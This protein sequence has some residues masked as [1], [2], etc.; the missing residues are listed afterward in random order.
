MTYDILIVDDQEDIRQLLSD[1][2]VDEG[3]G[4]RV[5]ASGIEALSSIKTKRPHLILLDVWLKEA[6]CDGLHVLDLIRQI[7]PELPIIMISGHSSI[8]TAIQALKTGAYDF[9]EKPFKTERLLNTIT[10]ALEHVALRQEIDRLNDLNNHPLDFVGQSPMAEQSRHFIGSVSK[11]KSRVLLAGPSGSGKKLIASLIHKRSTR[12]PNPL[13]VVKCGLLNPDT[14]DV[15]FYGKEASTVAGGVAIQ[16]GLLEK[17]HGGTIVLD[18]VHRTPAPIQ[19]RLLKVVQ[20]QR[21]QRVGGKIALENDVRFISTTEENLEKRVT[22]GTFRSDLFYRLN[23]VSLTLDPLVQRSEDIMALLN[24]F[25]NASTDLSAPPKRILLD[26]QMALESYTWPGNVRQLRNVVEW[27]LI[28]HAKSTEISAAML[29]ADIQLGSHTEGDK[30]IDRN[31]VLTLQLKEARE[32]FEKAYLNLH[33]KRFNG[34]ISKT[35][36]AIGMERTALHRKIK[37]L[38]II[39]YDPSVGEL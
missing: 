37:M 38:Q 36:Q 6:S 31:H 11:T 8:E 10:R 7:H 35:A 23:V 16:A 15:E 14:F 29:P 17:A 9:I 39:N 3:Y 13:I 26:A 1:I 32:E 27:L 19:E 2:L 12:A 21:Y 4:T 5:A 24:S 30:F 22:Q 28:L 18:D 33:M 25:L 34:N 20:D